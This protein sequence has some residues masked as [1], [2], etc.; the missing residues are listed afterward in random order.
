MTNKNSQS[1]KVWWT[2]KKNMGEKWRSNAVRCTMLWEVAALDS[3]PVISCP[4]TCVSHI[5][6]I[7]IFLFYRSLINRPMDEPGPGQFRRHRD[8]MPFFQKN[9]EDFGNFVWK[10]SESCMS[11]MENLINS[12]NFCLIFKIFANGVP[13]IWKVDN[14]ASNRWWPE[15]KF[16]VHSSKPFRWV[17][18]TRG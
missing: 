13:K 9:V 7:L 4:A 12:L 15:K 10:K 1:E 18:L 14:V 5:K 17:W 2:D 6:L 8:A 16:D 11:Y 3:E